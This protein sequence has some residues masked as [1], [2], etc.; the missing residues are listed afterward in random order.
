MQTVFVMV[1]VPGSGKSTRA[2]ELAEKHQATII[3]SDKIRKMLF[4]NEDDQNHNALVFKTYYEFFEQCLKEGRNVILDAT[5]IDMDV[6]K[7][8]FLHIDDLVKNRSINR[9]KVEVVAYVVVAPESL[10]VE[11]DM[12]RARRVGQDIIRMYICKFQFPQKFEGF[13][14]VIVDEAVDADSREMIAS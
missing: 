2:K 11:R 12:R 10:C 8:I 3:S 7:K 4:D 14:N 13:D 9:E 5:N 6:R 1:G